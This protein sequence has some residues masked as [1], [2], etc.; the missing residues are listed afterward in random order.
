MAQL[1]DTILTGETQFP[2]STAEVKVTGSRSS[3]EELFEQIKQS[4]PVGCSSVDD[5]SEIK[6]TS[7]VIAAEL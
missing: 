6:I 1:I 3:H 5:E 7:Q 2:Q 4:W